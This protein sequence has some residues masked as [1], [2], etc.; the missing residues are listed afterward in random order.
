[1]ANLPEDRVKKL[2]RQDIIDYGKSKNIIEDAQGSDGEGKLTY[3][4]MLAQS[5]ADRLFE[6]K[7]A[8][9][10]AKKEKLTKLEEEA[11]AKAA[12]AGTEP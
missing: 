12:E 3:E 8:A 1:M 5:A 7:A 10:K 2:T 6:M 11:N 9:R 4:Q